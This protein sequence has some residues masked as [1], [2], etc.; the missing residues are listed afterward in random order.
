MHIYFLRIKHFKKIKKKVYLVSLIT[1]LFCVNTFAQQNVVGIEFK[2]ST[3]S[4]NK[5]IVNFLPLSNKKKISKGH[6]PPFPFSVA[7]SSLIYQQSYETKNLKIKGETIYGQDIYARGDT[8]VQN[9]TAGELKAWISPNIWILPCVNVYAI[10]G[11]TSGQINP[12]LLVKG[13]IIEDIPNIGDFFIDTTYQLTDKITYNG[14]TFGFG[15]T[16]SFSVKNILVFL[17]YHYTVTNADELG[18]KIYNNF[19]STKVGWKFNSKNEN[20]QI[21]AW[22]GALY[23]Q[24]DQSFKGEINV[25]EI[26]AELV[27]YFGD[28]AEYYGTIKATHKWNV[29]LGSS[30]TINKHHGVYIEI[31]FAN[32]TQASIGYEFMF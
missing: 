18:G 25:E 3:S 23:F 20:F 27:P 7:F 29:L 6:I 9:S 21:K 8:I 1:L 14:S 13:I 4:I 30:L 12:D 5:G 16:V 28:T 2:N 10:F 26:A 31:G 15:L 17:D 22:I 11:Y 19:A 24:N 32:R